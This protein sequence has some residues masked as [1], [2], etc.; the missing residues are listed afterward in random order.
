[1]AVIHKQAQE[2]SR[3]FSSEQQVTGRDETYG[4]LDATYG[5]WRRS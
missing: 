2:S 4:L 3:K 5:S 1:M